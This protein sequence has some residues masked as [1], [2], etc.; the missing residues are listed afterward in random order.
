MK[1]VSVVTGNSARCVCETDTIFKAV[2]Q[3]TG[4]VRP[5][6]LHAGS[7]ALERE[8]VTDRRAPNLNSDQREAHDW[9]LGEPLRR[10]V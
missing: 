1:V 7:L 4:W 8:V 5:V 6:R 9:G 3:I 10:L 2:F